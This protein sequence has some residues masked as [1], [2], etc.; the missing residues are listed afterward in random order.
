MYDQNTTL[1]DHMVHQDIKEYR[2]LHPAD[3]RSDDELYKELV[4]KY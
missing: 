3:S 1:L 2:S 4:Q